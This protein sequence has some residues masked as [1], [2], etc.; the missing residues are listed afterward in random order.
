MQWALNCSIYQGTHHL[1]STRTSTLLQKSLLLIQKTVKKFSKLLNPSHLLNRLLYR[2]IIQTRNISPPKSPI[3]LIQLLLRNLLLHNLQSLLLGL[4]EIILVI[5]LFL[6]ILDN[7]ISPGI[8]RGDELG[9][10]AHDVF[11]EFPGVLRVAEARVQ[12]DRRRDGCHFLSGVYSG[13]GRE[14]KVEDWGWGKSMVEMR[15]Y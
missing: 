8:C 7:Q 15:I 14:V 13:V 2:P 1:N 9:E 10:P 12:R 5:G 3:L 6:T 11:S 4:L